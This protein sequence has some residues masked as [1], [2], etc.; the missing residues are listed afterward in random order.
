[1]NVMA[2]MLCE[3]VY[4]RIA[5]SFD[6]EVLGVLRLELG[7]WEIDES[8]P[9]GQKTADVVRRLFRHSWKRLGEDMTAR[10]MH[11]PGRPWH[12]PFEGFHEP[13][14]E[15]AREAPER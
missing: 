12:E 2:R 5:T 9:E 8:T 6:A 7:C 10:L 3:V 1:M 11:G 15:D 4:Q 13:R 14:D